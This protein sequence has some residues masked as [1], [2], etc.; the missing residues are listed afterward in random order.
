MINI[1]LK[2]PAIYNLWSIVSSNQVSEP[3][4]LLGDVLPW[5]SASRHTKPGSR[6]WYLFY[7]KKFKL[8]PQ[9]QQY[10]L[11]VFLMNI[12]YLSA[13]LKLPGHVDMKSD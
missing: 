2:D 11:S 6:V 1:F 3:S 4:S 13:Q 12:S 8:C 9:D 7:A 10:D 5:P